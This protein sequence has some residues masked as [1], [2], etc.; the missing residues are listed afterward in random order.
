L[1]KMDYCLLTYDSKLENYKY[2]QPTKFYDCL[3]I[4][5]P[6]ICAKGMIS[7]EKHVNKLT[8]N[9]SVD[10]NS[11]E[12]PK[13]VKTDFSEYNH[14]LYNSSYQYDYVLNKFKKELINLINKI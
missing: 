3:S 1:S 8:Q 10:Y 12:F 7:L 4:G 14:N 6:Y 11:I 5:L 2:I 9:L 13:L